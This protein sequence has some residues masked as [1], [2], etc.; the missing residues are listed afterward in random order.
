MVGT[1]PRQARPAHPFFIGGAGGAGQRRTGSSSWGTVKGLGNQ[2]RLDSGNQREVVT[3]AVENPVVVDHRDV[4]SH[5]DVVHLLNVRINK[6]EA[7][8]RVTRIIR[9]PRIENGI[10]RCIWNPLIEEHDIRIALRWSRQF[11][12]AERRVKSEYEVEG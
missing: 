5:R 8:D 12:E 10:D 6:V 3:D 11:E 7:V 1:Q 9:E 2:L 4:Y